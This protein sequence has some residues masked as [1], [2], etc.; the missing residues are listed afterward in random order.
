M[1]VL[2]VDDHSLFRKGVASLLTAHHIEVIGEA[3][4]GLTAF[5]M[6]RE[7]HP[8]VIL[9]DIEM[10][11]CDGL[12]ATRLIK[13][14]L[15]E[16]KIIILSISDEDEHLFEAIKSGA[17]GYLLKRSRSEE[18][19]ERF[20]SLAEGEL[21]F[22][23]GLGEKVLVEF[24]RLAK[25]SANQSEPAES[26][27]ALENWANSTNLTERQ[28]QVLTLVVQGKSYEEIGETLN[29]SE[30]TI[31]Y[32]MSLILKRLNMDNRAQVIAFFARQGFG[33]AK[34]PKA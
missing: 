13:A 7:L 22:S 32:H 11:I 15:P 6:A 1:R 33:G 20:R 12:A 25:H 28:V 27:V 14:E 3:S 23:K 10:P 30:R 2:L 26:E 4:D 34:I 5:E 29:L 16:I 31:K 18:F 8:D 17:S 9:M 24:A 21:T 19:L